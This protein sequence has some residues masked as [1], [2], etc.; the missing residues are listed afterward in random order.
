MHAAYA[1]VI[2]GAGYDFPFRCGRATGFS[3]LENP[4][5][6]AGD[7]TVLE[8]GMVFAVDGSVSTT[9]FRAQVGDSFIITED[10]YEA[11]THHPKSV[12]EV[13]I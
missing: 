13:I 9:G 7:A 6:V 4:Q 8:P 5:L 3:Y 10:G 12:D 11:I 2:Q 1:E